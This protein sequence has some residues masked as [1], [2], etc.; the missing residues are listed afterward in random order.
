MHQP[1]PGFL[2]WDDELHQNTKCRMAVKLRLLLPR[3][4]HQ[5]HHRDGDS[6][7]QQ[8][9]GS[10]RS[11]PF[12]HR[13]PRA[14]DRRPGPPDVSRDTGRLRWG[15]VDKQ[16]PGGEDASQRVDPSTPTPPAV[17]LTGVLD[18]RVRIRD[19][20]SLGASRILPYPALDNTP[21]PPCPP[22]VLSGED[23]VRDSSRHKLLVSRDTVDTRLATLMISSENMCC[24][25]QGWLISPTLL[26]DFH[27]KTSHSDLVDFQM[28]LAEHSSK[29]LE[30][31]PTLGRGIERRGGRDTRVGMLLGW[32][33]SELSESSTLHPRWL[34]QVRG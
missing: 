27:V 8:Q 18:E 2:D 14:P 23:S 28:P 6:R 21:L 7:E 11:F 17:P 10:G 5:L 16:S 19:P 9:N 31:H 24:E 4:E 25:P 34:V 12:P 26:S 20:G 33:L 1:P 30:E 3:M 32:C 13:C 22:R 29:F 15:T